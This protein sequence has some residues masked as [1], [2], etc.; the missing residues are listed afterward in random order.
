MQY[1]HMTLGFSR[2]GN[3]AYGLASQGVDMMNNPGT[4]PGD[5]LPLALAGGWHDR[6]FFRTM[7]SLGDTDA[8]WRRRI[9]GVA[10]QKKSS[11]GRNGTVGS[12]QAEFFAFNGHEDLWHVDWRAR[13]SLST[14]F[15]PVPD[16][17]RQFWVH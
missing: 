17:L 10:A 7:S 1:L 5:A 3:H 15:V 14:P 2:P 16:E 8:A 12:A 13:L 4:L 9:V 11:D 6:R